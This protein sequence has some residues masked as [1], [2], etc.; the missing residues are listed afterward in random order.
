RRLVH[1]ESGSASDPLL[2]SR[3]GDP[4]RA[5]SPGC[6]QSVAAPSQSLLRSDPACY[7]SAFEAGHVLVMGS[8]ASRAGELACQSIGYVAGLA[9]LLGAQALLAAMHALAEGPDGQGGHE[10]AQ[11]QDREAHPSGEG[12]W[13]DHGAFPPINFATDRS[14]NHMLSA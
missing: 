4:V 8:S 10:A 9:H 7:Q 3:R 1:Q 2:D 11:D 6:S 13:I 14:G 5:F 12:S